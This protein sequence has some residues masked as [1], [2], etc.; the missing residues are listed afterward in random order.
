MSGKEVFTTKARRTRRR[1]RGETSFSVTP[2]CLCVS[3]VYPLVVHRHRVRDSWVPAQAGT[4]EGRFSNDTHEAFFTTKA[5]FSSC[6][7]GE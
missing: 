7:R 1:H 5:I 2:L 3:V 6:L 4:T